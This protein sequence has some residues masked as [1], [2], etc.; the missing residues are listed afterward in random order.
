[1]AIVFCVSACVDSPAP[2]YKSVYAYSHIEGTLIE[3]VKG[4]SKS[5][6]IRNDSE[7]AAKVDSSQN[8]FSEIFDRID[9]SEGRFKAHV[10]ATKITA[11]ASWDCVGPVKD[12]LHCIIWNASV[13]DTLVFTLGEGRISAACYGYSVASSDTVSGSTLTSFQVFRDSR[14]GY[15]DSLIQ[16]GSYDTLRVFRGAYIY[17]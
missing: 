6:V 16:A 1:M 12:T 14:A 9:Q 7:Y 10:L 2:G 8:R 11:G 5:T 17:Q 15:Y 3:Y 13:A 4:A